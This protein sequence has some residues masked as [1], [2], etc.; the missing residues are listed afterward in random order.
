MTTRL[1]TTQITDASLFGIQ[2]AYSRFDTAQARVNTGK[3]VQRPSDNPTGV[4]QSLEYRERV[5]ELDQFSRTI[6]SAK[7]FAATSEAALDNIS[8]LTRQARTLGV[9]A[10][11]DGVD[12]QSRT[13]IASQLQNIIAQ[14]ASIANTK[15]GSQYVFA[16]QRTDT[17]P[18]QPTTTGYQYTGGTSATNDADITLDIGRS[19]SIKV[20]V[21][22][23][24]VFTPLLAALGKL[25]DDTASAATGQVSRDDLASVDTQINNVLGAR[26]DLGSRVQ[27][28]DLTKLRNDVTKQ[29]Y[30]KFISNIEDADIPTS[31]VELQTAQTAYQAALQSTSRTFQNSLLDFI[32]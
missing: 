31:V 9:Q 18:I 11:S 6:D 25:R 15:Y 8:S 2:E 1:S 24:Q 28:L 22:G 29:N 26:A 13:A 16:G 17:A 32:K 10:A 7:G 27:R 12:S 5:S 19:E 30:T 20:N 3:Q 4:A 14:V 21:P 23:D